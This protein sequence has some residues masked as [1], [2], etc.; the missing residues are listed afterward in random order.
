MGISNTKYSTVQTEDEKYTNEEL[1]F[2]YREVIEYC[3]HPK[4]NVYVYRAIHKTKYT[5]VFLGY[6]NH[7]DDAINANYI[8]QRKYYEF[9]VELLQP[10]EVK[11]D[12][13]IVL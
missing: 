9:L 3:L 12:P 10:E 4:L 8:A 7:L 1:L 11:S 5:R 2:M 13:D 6:Y